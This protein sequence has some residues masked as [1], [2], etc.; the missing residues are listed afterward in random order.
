MTVGANPPRYPTLALLVGLLVGCA[1]QPKA[2]A[3]AFGRPTSLLDVPE[4]RAKT[5]QPT[6]VEASALVPGKSAADAPVADIPLADTPGD[7]L[8]VE[9]RLREQVASAGD[10]TGPA[11]ELAERLVAREDLVGALA[12]VDAAL[13]RR[14]TVSLRVARADLL[15]DLGQ[16]H[17]AVAE[18]RTLVDDLTIPAT[19]PDCLFELAELEWLEG[20]QLAATKA[21]DALIG[22]HG[23]T[24]WFLA[25]QPQLAAL[26]RE[27][28][29]GG[30]P[31]RIRLRDLLGSLRGAPSPMTRLRILEGLV[32]NESPGQGNP[33]DHRAVRAIAI[34]LG[35]ESPAVRARAVQLA[36]PEPAD[37]AAFCAAGLADEAPLV[38]RAAIVRS[39]ELQGR[40]CVV[41][42]LTRLAA[43]DDPDC[44]RNLHEALQR[45]VTPTP[46]I[47]LDDPADADQRRATVAAWRLSCSP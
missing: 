17:L 35:D 20:N 32:A 16:R 6:A 47:V 41:S 2:S 38:R 28:A 45:Q 43:E 29:A 24:D 7:G 26:R 46:T 19:P 10:P 40:D 34:A 1:G 33:N 12:A 9:A 8:A 37:I 25:N 31:Q 14:H 36:Q 15:R 4:T 27:V 22:Q 42:L 5:D 13:A 11:L 44:F 39:E 18:L 30:A 23:A 3:S 21:L